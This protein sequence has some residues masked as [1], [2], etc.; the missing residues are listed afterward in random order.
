MFFLI[1]DIGR[2]MYKKLKTESDNLLKVQSAI[3]CKKKEVATLT[4]EW[5]WL[6]GQELDEAADQLYAEKEKA[7]RK[8]IELESA[9]KET[10]KRIKK[11][12]AT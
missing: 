12:V 5:L 10:L 7:E 8:L 6:E 9:A 11:N 3:R 1:D 2:A 4:E